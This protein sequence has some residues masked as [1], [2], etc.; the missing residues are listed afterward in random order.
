MRGGLIVITLLLGASAAAAAPS[1]DETKRVAEAANVLT[2]VR[3][4]SDQSIPEDVWQRARCVAVIPGVKKA[5]LVFG[6]E[7]GK[8][9]MSCRMPGD[10]WS[11]PAFLTLEKGSWGAQVGAESTGVVLLVMNDRGID[12]LLQDKVTLG[13]DASL[14]AGPVGRSGAAATDAQ[15]QA[16]MLSYSH[17]RGLFAGIDLSGGVLRPD[18]SADKDLYGRSIEAREILM[19]A[20]GPMQP[21]PA[22]R[23]FMTALRNVSH[24]SASKHG[25]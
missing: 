21:P 7:Y 19:A 14:A 25:A 8:G 4:S 3:S 15:L 22:A 16:E 23:P 5:A 24:Q 11:A 10:G 2:E 12:R 20:H 1:K 13:A 9:V 18:N 6:G 17:A